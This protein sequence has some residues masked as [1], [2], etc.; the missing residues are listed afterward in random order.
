VIGAEV[1]NGA[2]RT[3]KRVSGSGASERDLQNE[4][5]GERKSEKLMERRAAIN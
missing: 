2:E 4:R 3:E 5:S 1:E